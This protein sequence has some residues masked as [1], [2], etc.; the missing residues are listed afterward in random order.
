[1]E[2]LKAR[3]AAEWHKARTILLCE[4]R[5]ETALGLLVASAQN[6]PRPF[7]LEAAQAEHRRFRAAL[8]SRGAM[9]I[10]LRD[11]LTTGCREPGTMRE[12]LQSAAL[13]NIEFDFD[14]GL[15]ESQRTRIRH[16]AAIALEGMAPEH[17]AELLLLR[18]T[19]RVARNPDA[20]DATTAF[21]A[22]YD[23][24][25]ATNSYY[26]RDP[27]IT[28]GAGCTIGR[29]RLAVRQPENA[30]AELALRALGIEP[31][32]RVQAPGTLEGGDFIP[33]GDFVLQGQ[34]L[35][36][37]ADGV[38]QCLAARAYGRVEVGVVR[39]ERA[40]M[41]EMHLDC[42][43][44][45]FDHDLCALCDD[46]VGDTEPL[47]DVYEPHGGADFT[48][49]LVRT[50]RLRAYLESKGMRILGFSTKQRDGF[51]A[52][53]LLIGPRRYVCPAQSGHAWIELLREAGVELE[54][55]DFA[56]LTG[57]YGG[58]HC[59]SQVLVRG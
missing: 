59:S 45:V 50:V 24:R 3:Q 58:P 11:A 51:A 54:I 56:Q 16:D 28:S 27:L 55:L 42:Y 33:C 5:L 30:I 7:G 39:D 40:Q 20:L 2:P 46:R 32:C 37:N 53:G 36:T 43:L 4:P 12:M 17:L 34:G 13:K 23:L 8:E 57:G 31:L 29:L 21:V 44:A 14:D 1:M 10:D 47:V 38:A 19:V 52:N 35:L 15:D 48:Y 22:R 41:D 9:V 49:R 26:L 6:F 18:P 25:A